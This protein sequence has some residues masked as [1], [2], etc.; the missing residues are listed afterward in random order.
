[1]RGWP[2]EWD[3]TETEKE[4]ER[5]KPAELETHTDIERV[6]SI[7]SIDTFIN[8]FFLSIFPV[9]LVKS[10]VINNSKDVLHLLSYLSIFDLNWPHYTT[11]QHQL[12]C[13]APYLTLPLSPAMSSIVPIQFLLGVISARDDEEPSSPSSDRDVGASRTDDDGD[14]VGTPDRDRQVRTRRRNGRQKKDIAKTGILLSLSWYV[15][16]FHVSVDF[17]FDLNLNFLIQQLFFCRANDGIYYR[18]P[19]QTSFVPAYPSSICNFDFSSENLFDSPSTPSSFFSSSILTTPL[20]H[21]LSRSLIIVSVSVSTPYLY[22][23]LSSLSLLLSSLMSSL[24]PPSFLCFSW[25]LWRS[26]CSWRDNFSGPRKRDPWG[27]DCVCSCQV[28]LVA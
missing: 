8:R 3:S 6:I 27:P 24:L 20:T 15:I 25:I 28:I 4:R 19:F 18:F 14:N 23:C 11:P 16:S 17:N 10:S 2:L 1:M 12:F 5:E 22:H 13:I 7:W 21:P 9:I 26:I